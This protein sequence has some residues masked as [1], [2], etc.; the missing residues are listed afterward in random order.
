MIMK[1]K[2]YLFSLPT[3]D[4]AMKHG[5]LLKGKISIAHEENMLK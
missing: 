1:L 2:H 3:E 4:S 5:P